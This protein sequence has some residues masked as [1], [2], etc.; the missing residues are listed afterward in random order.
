MVGRKPV[1][2][3]LAERVSGS[4]QAKARL[5]VLLETISGAKSMEGACQV[6]GIH[7]TQLFKLRTRM[8]EAAAAA[9]EP[10]PVGRP[11]Q[12][13]DPQAARIAELEAQIKQ[14]EVEL[15]AARLRVELAQ[16]LRPAGDTS[17]KRKKKV[18]RRG[19]IADR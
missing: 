2:P 16:A 11:L 10:G 13:A 12:T 15:H 14:L 1:G 7:K 18:R 3:A 5:E 8:L 6:L 4:E 9:L 19:R 17:P